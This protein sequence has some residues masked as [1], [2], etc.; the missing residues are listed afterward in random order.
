MYHP[1]AE[2]FSAFMGAPMEGFFDGADV[3]FGTPTPAAPAA[4]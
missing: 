1:T 3:V 2:E 4:A